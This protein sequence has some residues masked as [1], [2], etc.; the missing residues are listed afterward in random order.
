MQP[1]SG[2]DP[3]RKGLRSKLAWHPEWEPTRRCSAAGFP[4]QFENHGLPQDDFA[5]IMESQACWSFQGH[6]KKVNRFRAN[7]GGVAFGVAVI[8]QKSALAFGLL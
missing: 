8:F 2:A 1:G 4:Q 7:S 3:A 5:C 6:A